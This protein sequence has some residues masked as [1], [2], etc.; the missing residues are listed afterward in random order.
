MS[1][2]PLPE[3]VAIASDDSVDQALRG[4][5]WLIAW[6]LSPGQ[7]VKTYDGT[8]R[9]E[10]TASGLRIVSGDL[11]QRPLRLIR[12][13]GRFPTLTIGAGPDPALGIPIQPRAQYRYY[14]RVTSL[15]AADS[16]GSFSISYEM[17]KY[18]VSNESWANEGMFSATMVWIGAPAGYPSSNEYAEGDVK[19]SNG[20]IVGRLT[21]GWISAT[22]R[23]ASVEIDT[24]PGCKQPLDSG[25]GQSWD[26][27]FKAL[28][29]DVAVSGDE[30][31]VTLAS[32][33]SGQWTDAQIHEAMLAHRRS[34]NLDTAWHFHI[35][36]VNII[37]STPRGIMY[38]ADATDSNKVPREGVG[39]GND[40]RVPNDPE[41]GLE[42]GK[43]FADSKPLFFRTAVHELGHAM[44]LFHDTS[45]NG[46]MNTTDVIA[47]SGSATNP[48]P[49]NIRWQYATQGLRGLRHFPDPYVRPG[50]VEFGHQSFSDPT[51]A[52]VNAGHLF[53]KLDLKMTPLQ[54]EVPL[55]AP[56]R[57]SIELVNSGDSSALVPA[58]ISLKSEYV[59]G[60]VQKADGGIR[61][62]K[63]LIR[64]VD[65]TPGI[66]ELKPGESI[67][68]SLTLLRGGQGALFH[69]SGLFDVRVT[70]RWPLGEGIFATQ[71][72]HT[73]VFVLPP[74]NAVQARAAH[75]ILATPDTQLVLV[76][77]QAR[78]GHLK[79]G[80]DAIKAATDDNVL[81]EHYAAV[82]ARRLLQLG[83]AERVQR[84][85]RLIEG[86]DF[87][88]S[89]PEK[90]KLQNLFRKAQDNGHCVEDANRLVEQKL[91]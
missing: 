3:P 25:L 40:W 28:G 64:C 41:W 24:A 51:V 73:T 69:S 16:N 52:D 11:Y 76:M 68:T 46:F 57:V 66:K 70:L 75:T 54:S 23:K 26:S 82:E 21:M 83:D 43:R 67:R 81:G 90:V 1:A 84:A 77:G 45:D 79:E 15:G 22:Y 71:S 19:T 35:L 63:P 9:V 47:A 91:A 49:N 2:P 58:D 44:G 6:R 37:L 53:D 65:D 34:V 72:G 61:T 36:S 20:A 55:G 5:C 59:R 89:G 39:I 14:L 86:K 78:K 4:G 74:E 50:G 60:K 88:C 80:V 48:F 87:I 33:A 32:V 8:L 13:Q 31:N 27:V 30:T 12:R 56:V 38:D 85:L 62:F 17:W 18:E 10:P 29:W 7:P 42:Q